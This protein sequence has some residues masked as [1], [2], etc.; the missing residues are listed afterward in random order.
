MGICKATSCSSRLHVDSTQ[1]QNYCKEGE[2]EELKL[3]M[4]ADKLQ[5]HLNVN[6]DPHAS[7]VYIALSGDE[8]KVTLDVLEAGGPFRGKTDG[9]GDSKAVTVT[10]DKP[11][12]DDRDQP[13]I[14]PLPPTDKGSE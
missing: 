10:C 14:N 4:S 1:R 11:P 13:I 8:P 5:C 2:S 3:V 7:E 6:W 12:E 9:Y